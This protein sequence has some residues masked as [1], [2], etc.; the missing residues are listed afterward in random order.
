MPGQCRL[1]YTTQFCSYSYSWGYI[2]WDTLISSG[3]QDE[4][5]RF[6]DRGLNVDLMSYSMLQLANNDQQALLDPQTLMDTA[7]QTFGIFFKHF[8]CFNVS[9]KLG[10]YVYDIPTLDPRTGDWIGAYGGTANATLST[11]VAELRMSPTAA[12]MSMTILV[13]LIIVTIIVYTTNRKEYKAIPRDVDTLASTFGWVYASKRLLAWAEIAPQSEPYLFPRRPSFTMLH[14]A[15]MGSFKDSDGNEHWGIELV[16]TDS[17]ESMSSRHGN[18]AMKKSVS[19]G[20]SIELQT[21]KPFG[22]SDSGES[23]AH[24]VHER[25]LEPSDT[26]F[27]AVSGAE[28]LLGNLEHDKGIGR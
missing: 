24:G 10:G 2:F 25:L 11:T 9:E 13:F 21:R 6:Q 28:E 23:E 7:N 1:Y 3:L 26:G 15:R 5:F 14:K 20:E 18:N 27:E 12:T 17:T 22:A 19:A 16:D 8:A 4:Y